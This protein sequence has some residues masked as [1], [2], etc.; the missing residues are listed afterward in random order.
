MSDNTTNLLLPF[1]LAAQAQKHVTVNEAFRLLDGLVQLTVL[2]RTRT[3]PPGASAEGDA[4]LVAIGATGAWDGWDGDIALRADGAWVRLPV[5]EGW[6]AYVAAEQ[7]LY[8]RAGSAWVPTLRAAALDLAR[9]SFG[10]SVG[11]AVQEQVLSSMSGATVDSSILIPDRTILLGVSTRTVTTIT[12]ATS[13]DCGIAGEADKFGAAL[14]VAAG[15]TNAGV[16]GPQAF[17]ADT[18]VRLTANG[19]NF[20]GGA[21]RVAL[22]YLTVGVPAS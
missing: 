16:I 7:A 4:H 2:D 22:H 12:G 15:S 13:Y 18:A 11:V 17:Y 3:S 20:T 5:R 6:R 21:V 8:L 9:A 1:V 10:G 14:G 19:G